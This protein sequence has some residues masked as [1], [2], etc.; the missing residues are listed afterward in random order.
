MEP[1]IESTPKPTPTSD[2]EKLV[3]LKHPPEQEGDWIVYS[4]AGNKDV[5]EEEGDDLYGL[6]I[7][8]GHY[9]KRSLAASRAREITAKTGTK[10][11]ISLLGRWVELHSRPQIEH[12][13]VVCA[14]IEGNIIRI[15]DQE[16]T[17]EKELY[18]KQ[19]QKERDYLRSQ[20]KVKMKDL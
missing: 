17:R 19:R 9:P 10:V 16:F 18:E 8:L 11:H 6:L 14:D 12:S 20:N 15:Q 1:G 4:F 3:T 2:L 5:K 13:E 7:Y